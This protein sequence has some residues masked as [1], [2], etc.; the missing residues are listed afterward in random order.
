M[1]YEEIKEAPVITRF[2]ENG[3]F[4]SKFDEISILGKGGFGVVYKAKYI[5]DNNLYALKKVK[6]HL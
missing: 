1:P 6:L 3:R 4:K 5:L 2:L